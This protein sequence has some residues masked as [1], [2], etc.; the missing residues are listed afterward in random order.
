MKRLLIVKGCVLSLAFAL[1][2][3]ESPSAKLANNDPP[4]EVAPQPV[5]QQTPQEQEWDP[6]RDGI[7]D[8]ID[9][10]RTEAARGSR[11]S[12]PIVGIRY[13]PREFAEYVHNAVVPEWRKPRHWRPIRIVLHNTGIPKIS[14]RPDG[15]TQ[16]NMWALAH[17]YGVKQGWSAG[18]H[19]FI[20]E[21]GIWVF[22]PL[23]R[24]G[25]HSPSWNGDSWGIEQLGDFT[26]EDYNSGDGAKIRDNTI[27]AL[28]VLT[29]AS[30][31]N[32]DTLHFH[33][34][35]R[36]S[37]HRGCPGTSCEKARV[38]AAVKAKQ[39]DWRAVW[40]SLSRMR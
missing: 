27:D 37:S 35:D 25:T 33:K 17:Y 31:I 18:P 1:M 21:H 12:I 7:G 16:T 23:T 6:L 9:R 4:A 26:L 8:L 24:R 29:I 3:G 22:S 28:A 20:D 32:I 39:G 15:F 34:E 5:P 40:D 13:T 14:Q 38:I 19:A 30:G 36:R 11:T 10:P 2:I